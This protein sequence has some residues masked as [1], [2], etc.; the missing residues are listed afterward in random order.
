[1]NNIQRAYDKLEETRNQ[2]PEIAKQDQEYLAAFQESSYWRVLKD[3]IERKIA[4][5]YILADDVSAVAEGEMSEAEFGKVALRSRFAAGHLQD[6]IDI[7][8]K[9]HQW[10]QEESDRIKEAKK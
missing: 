9:T 7:V 6:I 3:L 4:A 1:M 8:E 5:L 2:K 10:Y